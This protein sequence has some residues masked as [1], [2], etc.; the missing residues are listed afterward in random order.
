MS[1]LR[2]VQPGQRMQIPAAAYNA[3]VDAANYTK[4][5]SLSNRGQDGGNLGAGAVLVRNAT[6]ADLGRFSIVGIDGPVIS[7][8]D[9]LIEFQNRI[10]LSGVGPY[11][12]QFAVLLEPLKAGAIGR[13]CVSGECV[14][15]VNATDSGH[16]F[17][18]ATTD[19]TRLE[20]AAS[21][22]AAILYKEGGTGEKWTVVRLGNSP[23]SAAPRVH[24]FAPGYMIGGPQPSWYEAM[25]PAGNGVSGAAGPLPVPSP[26]SLTTDF[27]C[28]E[29]G[30]LVGIRALAYGDYVTAGSIT[31]SIY[32]CDATQS[33][34][35]RPTAFNVLVASAAV[36]ASPGAGGVQA[37]SVPL[38]TPVPD[39]SGL[40]V[41]AEQ[42]AD[43]AWMG[44]GMP[45]LAAWLH[46]I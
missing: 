41:V 35:A 8:T 28:E 2:K 34:T 9:N 43:L 20:S 15:R 13:A 29:S 7:P 22:S 39:G 11:P 36:L 46:L 16:Q 42:S 38:D 30:T 40:V 24:R 44:N 31:F 14:C 18:E 19:P 6:G 3:F 25:T 23:G 26:L 27:L 45:G 17:A 32:Y 5:A 4:A 21:G 12:G 10:V 33:R 37:V 1:I